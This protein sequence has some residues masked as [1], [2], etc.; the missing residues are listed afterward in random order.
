MNNNSNYGHGNGND[1]GKPRFKSIKKYNKNNDY[2]QEDTDKKFDVVKSHGTDLLDKDDIKVSKEVIDDEK[3]NFDDMC[4][5]EGLK[6]N[7]L[8]GI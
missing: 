4:N 2:S 8:R 6:E 1:G 3:D 5:E 7:L